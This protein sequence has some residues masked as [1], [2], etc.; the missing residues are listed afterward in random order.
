MNIITWKN[1]FRVAVTVFILFLCIFYWSGISAV[2]WAALGSLGPLFAGLAI[3]YVI[4]MLMTFF[5]RHYFPK[6]DR[7]TFIGRTRRPI[8]MVGAIVTFL[9]IIGAIVYLIVPE[10]LLCVKFLIAEIPPLILEALRSQWIRELLPADMITQLLSI[11]WMSHITT[12]INTVGVGIGGAVN[13]VLSAVSSVISI[14][15]TVFL[16]TIFSVYFLYSKEKFVSQTRRLTVSYLPLKIS[17]KLTEI[18]HVLNE[19]FHKYIV[20]QCTE[21]VILGALCSLGMLI[22]RFPYPG[23]IGALIGFTA[24]IPVAGAY[25]GA[26][27]GA[28]MILTESPLKALLFILF[29]LVLQQLEGNLIYPKVVGGSIGLPAIWVLAAVTVGGA[30]MGIPGIIFSVPIA[31]TVYRL[32]KEALNQREKTAA[33]ESAE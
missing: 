3:A 27:V 8:C 24:L 18:F 26:I 2:I 31:A 6:K 30:L 29:I 1:C 4:N 33:A 15:V 17:K 23:M 5:E 10:L 7:S 32:I 11:D 21:A 9:I 13:V 12:I 25:I 16:S 28:V 22:F 14:V 19:S 20:G